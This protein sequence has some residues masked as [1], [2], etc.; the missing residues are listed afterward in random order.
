MTCMRLQYLQAY[1]HNMSRDPLIGRYAKTCLH[2]MRQTKSSARRLPPSCI[3]IAV[4][5]HAFISL[6]NRMLQQKKFSLTNRR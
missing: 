2:T 6:H 3:E 4:S 5:L 1:F